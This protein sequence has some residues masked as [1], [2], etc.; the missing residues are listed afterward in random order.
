MAKDLKEL[1]SHTA[2]RGFRNEN[3]IIK[4]S[5]TNVVDFSIKES[6]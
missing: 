4:K 3:N 2:K 5:T 6:L 1:G